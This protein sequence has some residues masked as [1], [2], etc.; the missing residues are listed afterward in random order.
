MILSNIVE[1][2]DGLLYICYN[3]VATIKF[4]GDYLKYKALLG[5]N[6]ELYNKHSGERCFIVMN[7]PSLNG[8]D[9]SLL[10]NETVFCANYFYRA[11]LAQ[12]IKPNY[13]CWLDSKI[14]YGNDWETVKKEIKDACPNAKLILNIRG[15]KKESYQKDEYYT[16]NKH[17]PSL[18]GVKCNLNKMC[19]GFST[20]AFYAM[21]AAIYMGFKKIYVLGLDFEPGAFKHFSDLGSECADP[22]QKKL[23]SEV[24]GNYWS[25]TKAHYEA[26]ALADFA[27]KMGCEIINLNSNSCIRAFSFANYEDVITECME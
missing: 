18:F 15:Y 14:F 4:W 6:K 25:Y 5:R 7:G 10:E 27:N 16:Y 3:F 22:N 20:V 11:P 13:Y 2:W 17:M 21:N 1:K 24:C 9:L 26:Y 19:S 8:H 12:I 23:K